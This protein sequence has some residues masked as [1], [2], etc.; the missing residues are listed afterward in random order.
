MSKI[1]GWKQTSTS[2]KWNRW[3]NKTKEQ[4]T[5]I[6]LDKDGSWFFMVKDSE[7]AFI[8]T[9]GLTKENAIKFAIA[10]MKSHPNG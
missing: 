4:V 3:R 5:H 2:S 1:T 10:Y 9:K 8:L 7:R 6:V